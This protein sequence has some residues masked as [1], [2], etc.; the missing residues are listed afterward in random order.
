MGRV[1]NNKILIINKLQF[2]YT[3]TMNFENLITSITTTDRTLKTEAVKAINK[4]LTARN[5][6]VG[7]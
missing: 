1:D 7:L 5:W 3:I 4:A 2:K 6:L